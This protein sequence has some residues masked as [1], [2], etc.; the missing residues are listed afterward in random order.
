MERIFGNGSTSQTPSWRPEPRERG[1]FGILSTCIVTLG[2]C[3]WTAIHL[4]LPAHGDTM[5]KQQWC[6]VRLDVAGLPR[7]RN[8]AYTAFRQYTTAWRLQH[9]MKAYFPTDD[10]TPVSQLSKSEGELEE[11]QPLGDLGGRRVQ[12]EE[13]QRIVEEIKA[14]RQKW[15]IVH[16]YFATMGGF[17]VQ[18]ADEN[19][20]QNFFPWRDTKKEPERYTQLTLTPEGL[21]Y[22]EEQFPGFIPNLSRT[23]I[24]D[25]SKGSMF[26]KAVVCLQASW[27]C[28]QC[29]TRF[30]QGLGIS[31]LELNTLAFY[32][33]PLVEQATRH[34]GT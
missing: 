24:K 17:A 20:H 10:R 32:L 21:C 6:K 22:L 34:R 25:K 28:F 13:K 30:I 26:A 23:S 7:S 31:L 29:L 33:R 18:I 16:S 12:H 8:V 11:G 5:M 9:K 14:T 27:F 2:L 4:N 15:T 1:T 19:G 3:V